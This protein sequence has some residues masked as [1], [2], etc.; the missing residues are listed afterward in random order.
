MIL[1]GAAGMKKPRWDIGI[2]E[3][4]ANQVAF[5]EDIVA[6]IHCRVFVILKGS[7]QFDLGRAAGELG[8]S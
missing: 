4:P 6:S 3:N 5:D 8:T 2:V 1:R 7:D